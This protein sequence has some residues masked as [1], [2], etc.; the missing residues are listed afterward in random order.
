[1]FWSNHTAVESGNGGQAQKLMV[2]INNKQRKNPS[3][4]RLD[5]RLTTLFFF[6]LGQNKFYFQKFAL[7]GSQ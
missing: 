4:L 7:A 1:V 5:R 2:R 3:I 6:S